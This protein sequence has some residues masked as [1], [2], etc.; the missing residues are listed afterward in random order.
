ML[1]TAPDSFDKL[2]TNGGALPIID[3]SPFMLRVSKH[4]ENFFSTRL[5]KGDE[6]RDFEFDFSC[7][8]RVDFENELMRQHVSVYPSSNP[9]SAFAFR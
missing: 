2:G 3:D 1:N 8:H 7:G 6:T 9:N 5:E 4:S